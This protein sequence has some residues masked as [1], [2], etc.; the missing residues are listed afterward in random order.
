MN[1]PLAS[2]RNVDA[3]NKN[4]ESGERLTTESNAPV[5]TSALDQRMSPAQ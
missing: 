2:S 1:A 5:A 3:R 4:V